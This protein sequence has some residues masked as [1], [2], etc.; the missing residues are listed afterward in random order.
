M[1][2]LRIRFRFYLV[3]LLMLLLTAVAYAAIAQANEEESPCVTG[4][5]V[6]EWDLGTGLVADCEALLA[7][8]D[9]LRGTASLNW[10]AT[11]SIGRWDGIDVGNTSRRVE[12]IE[13][14]RQGLNGSV[15]A[16][17]GRLD[18]LVELRLFSNGLTGP[19]PSE[20]GNLAQLEKLELRDNDLS[21]QLPETLNGLNSL[22]VLYLRGNAFTG[23]VPANLLNVPSSD[24]SRLGLPTCAAAVPTVAPTQPPQPTPVPT[25]PP[26]PGV[27]P[28]PPPTP[29]PTPIATPAPPTPPSESLSQMVRRVRPAVV[30][31]T[32]DIIGTDLSGSPLGTGFIVRTDDTGAAYIMTTFHVV[33]ETTNIKVLV[34]DAD[35][36][37][38]SWVRG[39]PRRDLALLRICCGT[40]T[41]VEFADSNV[42]HPGDEV[43]SIGYGADSIQP[44]KFKTGRRI[45]PGEATVTRGIVS[46]FRYDSG[47][48]A[49]LVQHD[50]PVNVGNS[51]GPLFSRDGRVAGVTVYSYVDNFLYEI[52]FEGLH[53]AVLETTAQERLRLW[54]LGPSDRFGPLRGGL[55]HNSDSFFESSSPDFTATGDE[56]ALWARFTNPYG[57]DEHYWTYGFAFGITDD[58]REYTVF[59]VDSE[60]RWYVWVRSSW[61]Q[62]A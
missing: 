56:F 60:G 52:A 58:W 25:Q 22:R 8:K 46:A 30:K 14:F 53:Y 45:V 57:A 54:T 23:C 31:V 28:T 51:G 59:E 16:E 11:R 44:R 37:D 3:G 15:P 32:G 26:L 36:F 50:A 9:T 29:I 12:T 1:T 62:T 17:L 24:V 18:Q 43:I 5:A 34:N 42:L 20:L 48:D 27:T 21:G 2:R 6:Y 19:L 41:T 7:A 33:E 35:L 10:S 47:M 4:G 38:A 40:F 49:Q 61:F 55:S 39:D 13:L